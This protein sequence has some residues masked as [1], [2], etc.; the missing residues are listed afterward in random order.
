MRDEVGEGSASVG[1]GEGKSRTLDSPENAEKPRAYSSHN[2][3]AIPSECR[4]LARVH[5]CL[6][7][8]EVLA[9]LSLRIHIDLFESS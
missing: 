2:V 8:L 3:L 7:F 6:Y 9:N 5:L 4:M 1:H